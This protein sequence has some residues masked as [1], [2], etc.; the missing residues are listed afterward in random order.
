MPRRR[1]SHSS[2]PKVVR[3]GLSD[4]QGLPA[5]AAAIGRATQIPTHSSTAGSGEMSADDEADDDRAVPPQQA[6]D[7]QQPAEARR[8]A[9]SGT[10]DR[11]VVRLRRPPRHDDGDDE[12]GGHGDGGGEQVE[13]QRDRQLEPPVDRVSRCGPRD[14]DRQRDGDAG[15]QRDAPALSAHRR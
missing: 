13:P 8:P 4:G 11:R 1:A 6:E 7:A 12:G 10:V 5:R 9:A 3:N 14:R 2:A 15:G